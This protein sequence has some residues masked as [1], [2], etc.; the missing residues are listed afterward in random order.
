MFEPQWQLKFRKS[1]LQKALHIVG[2]VL[3]HSEAQVV[4]KS[5]A[6]GA[7]NV[8]SLSSNSNSSEQKMYQTQGYYIHGSNSLNAFLNAVA[9]SASPLSP[10]VQFFQSTRSGRSSSAARAILH[11]APSVLWW[12]EAERLQSLPS[13]L[14]GE[15]SKILDKMQHFL[16]AR[17]LHK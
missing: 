12:K 5:V 15:R 11:I 8:P 3:S 13:N 4:L 7:S 2:L 14:E 9:S 6:S 1:R 10:T 17:E 16:A